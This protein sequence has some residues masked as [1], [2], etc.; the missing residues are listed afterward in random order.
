VEV[1]VLSSASPVCAYLLQ[2]ERAV[3]LRK[4]GGGAWSW[5]IDTVPP[6][7]VTG[8]HAEVGYGKLRLSWTR[9]ADADHSSSSGAL[10]PIRRRSR[11]TRERGGHAETKYV[12][13]LEHRYGFISFDKTGNASPPL[14]LTVGKGA[15]LLRPRRRDGSSCAPARSRGRPY[16]RLAGTATFQVR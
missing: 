16:G 13:S 12:N 6:S 10:A 7:Q 2:G 3:P 9:S 1:Q 14:G 8:V 5:T 15:L 11:S 4:L